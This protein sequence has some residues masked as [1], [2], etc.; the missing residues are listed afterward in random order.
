[1]IEEDTGHQFLASAD[2]GICTA[3]HIGIYMHTHTYTTMN[4]H[5]MKLCVLGGLERWL[6]QYS[7]CH[8]YMR[9]WVQIL[10]TDR[11]ARCGGLQLYTQH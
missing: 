3:D 2:S 4:T 10:S 9:A 6:R 1:M 5:M 7:A 8:P 11:R